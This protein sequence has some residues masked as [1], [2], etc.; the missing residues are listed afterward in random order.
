MQRCRARQLFDASERVMDTARSVGYL[1]LGVS[2]GELMEKLVELK[3][4]VDVFDRLNR[5]M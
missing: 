4:A 2:H 5:G 1:P 3:K